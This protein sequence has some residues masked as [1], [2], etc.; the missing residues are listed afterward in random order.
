[1][2]L[3]ASFV[4]SHLLATYDV[5]GILSGTADPKIYIYIF[6]YL[7]LF[8]FH[9]KII[10]LKNFVVFCQTSTWYRSF[11]KSSLN[12]WNPQFHGGKNTSTEIC[13]TKRQVHCWWDRE[14][15]VGCQRVTLS[16]DEMGRARENI[17]SSISLCLLFQLLP[18]A[19]QALS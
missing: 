7:N 16:L 15:P 11:F 4:C 12:W 9:W 14:K 13:N 2:T 1:M 19:G 17:D 6:I 8:I 10:A 3:Y 18:F 5:P